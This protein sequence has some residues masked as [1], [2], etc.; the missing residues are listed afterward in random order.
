MRQP[1]P[2]AAGGRSTSHDYAG[3]SLVRHH[4]Q[5]VHACEAASG[6]PSWRLCTALALHSVRLCVRV[7][8]AGAGNVLMIG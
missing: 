1:H 7:F 4:Q 6:Q 3:L 2:A 8:C 5:A